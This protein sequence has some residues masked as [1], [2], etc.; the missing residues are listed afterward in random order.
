MTKK[1]SKALDEFSVRLSRKRDAVT[2]LAL[3]WRVTM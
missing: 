2:Q 3:V 1:S